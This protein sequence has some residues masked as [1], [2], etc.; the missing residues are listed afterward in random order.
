MDQQDTEWETS[1]NSLG[2]DKSLE[3]PSTIVDEKEYIK[4]DGDAPQREPST[5]PFHERASVSKTFPVGAAHWEVS[6]FVDCYPYSNE[7]DLKKKYNLIR[8]DVKFKD[9]ITD[10]HLR[11]DVDVAILFS[12]GY[13]SL[14]LA[15]RHLEKGEC[16]SLLSVCFCQQEQFAAYLTFQV[17]RSIYGEEKVY[18]N[19]LLGPTYLEGTE[20]TEGLLQQPTTAFFATLMPKHIQSTAKTLE[21]AYCMNDDAISYLPEIEQLYYTAFSFKAVENDSFKIP[22][23]TFPLSKT[24]HASNIYYVENIERKR[25]VIFP[26]FS[27]ERCVVECYKAPK[28]LDGKE[29]D[30]YFM[31]ECAH[32]SNAKENKVCRTCGYFIKKEWGG[33]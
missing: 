28:S 9:E 30:E 31:I 27:S 5:D 19:R 15:L 4:S 18:F 7:I 10:S 1:T 26:T 29:G 25:R 3:K 16:V 32:N 2:V 33:F 13:D 11:E 12:G 8:L 20:S 22:K 23:I 21:F 17:L 24:K 14:S 6:R